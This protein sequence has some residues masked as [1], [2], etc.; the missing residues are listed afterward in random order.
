VLTELPWARESYEPFVWTDPNGDLFEV[1][2]LY[3]AKVS[4][5]HVGLACLRA[6]KRDRAVVWSTASL[7]AFASQLK[8]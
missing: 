1:L 7:S 2:V 3:S 4:P 5:A 6:G 8:G